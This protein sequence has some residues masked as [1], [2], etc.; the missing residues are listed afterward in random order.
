MPE[1]IR[2]WMFIVCFIIWIVIIIQFQSNYKNI[3]KNPFR[4]FYNSL[5]KYSFD[6][7][8]AIRINR[9]NFCTINGEKWIVFT[10]LFDISES[11]IKSGVF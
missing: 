10:K 9:S 5:Y 11:I 6:T 7:S 8:S 3:L 2:I 4:P 1:R